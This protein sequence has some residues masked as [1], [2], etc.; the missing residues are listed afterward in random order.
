MFDRSR[1][2]HAAKQNKVTKCVVESM[3]LADASHVRSQS[4]SLDIIKLTS[5]W[6]VN[7]ETSDCIGRNGDVWG[8]T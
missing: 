5:F 3:L 7:W 2:F 6:V 4:C 8:G 1:R